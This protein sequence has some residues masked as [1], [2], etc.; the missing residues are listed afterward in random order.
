LAVSFQNLDDWLAHLEGAHP[1]GIDMGLE[2]ISRVK[3]ALGL[4]LSA[5]AACTMRAASPFTVT[6]APTSAATI[7]HRRRSRISVYRWGFDC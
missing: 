6:K 4:S 5:V 2:R 3:Q 1:V 7:R